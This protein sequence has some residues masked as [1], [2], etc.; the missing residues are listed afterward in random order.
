M[1]WGAK[2]ILTNPYGCP[3]WGSENFD[4]DIEQRQGRS[5]R[6]VTTSPRQWKPACLCPKSTRPSE[7]STF[8]NGFDQETHAGDPRGQLSKIPVVITSVW[9]LLPVPSPDGNTALGE[10]LHVRLELIYP[11]SPP[12]AV[13]DAYRETEAQKTCCDTSSASSSA[14]AIKGS[15]TSWAR[16]TLV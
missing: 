6:D 10:L 8:V 15:A 3:S 1:I 14:P 16:N 4:N 12:R 5:A 11:W 2:T 13:V 9:V 7:T